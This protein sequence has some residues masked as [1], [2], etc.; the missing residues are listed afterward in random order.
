ML[1]AVATIPLPTDTSTPTELSTQ[2]PAETPT[3]PAEYHVGVGEDGTIQLNQVDLGARFADAN[4]DGH[5]DG[6][7]QTQLV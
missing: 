6:I 2:T 1:P 4:N 7:L 5:M 3:P